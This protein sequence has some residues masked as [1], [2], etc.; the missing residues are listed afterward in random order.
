VPGFPAS[1][2]AFTVINNYIK[3]TRR[4]SP[5]DPSPRRRPILIFFDDSNDKATEGAV[6]EAYAHVTG[7]VADGVP[8]RQVKVSVFR[9]LRLRRRIKPIVSP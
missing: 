9:R 5:R 3:V 6:R 7:L 4:V 8:R 1:L 2:G